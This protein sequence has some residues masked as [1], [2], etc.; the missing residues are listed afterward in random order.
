MSLKFVNRES[1]TSQKTLSV[2]SNILKKKTAF[3]IIQNSSIGYT[4]KQN[5]TDQF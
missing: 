5:L 3:I 1:S 2:F 4:E